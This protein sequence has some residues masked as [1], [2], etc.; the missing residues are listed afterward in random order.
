MGRHQ[1]LEF[2]G[3]LNGGMGK[4]SKVEGGVESMSWSFLNA[5][6]FLVWFFFQLFVCMLGPLL[7][8]N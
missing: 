4:K 3:Q 7:P 6:W 5:G 2:V 8:L 1:L